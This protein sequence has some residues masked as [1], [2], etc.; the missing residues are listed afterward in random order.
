MCCFEGD[1]LW[2]QS[3]HSGVRGLKNKDLGIIKGIQGRIWAD[4]QLN[5]ERLFWISCVYNQSLSSGVN[6]K[7]NSSS[8][9]PLLCFYPALLPPHMKPA[10]NIQAPLSSSAGSQAVTYDNPNSEPNVS[11]PPWELY[12]FKKIPEGTV[13]P[14]RQPPESS[15]ASA[16]TAG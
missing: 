13:V 16:L 1:N 7:A 4:L 8:N 2:W 6:D 9:V 10:P 11:G 3:A 15:S 14:A 5:G 12:N